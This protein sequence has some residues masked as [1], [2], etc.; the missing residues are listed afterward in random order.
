MPM[1]LSFGRQ[2]NIVRFLASNIIKIPTNYFPCKAVVS[3]PPIEQ[4]TE[5][6]RL[7]LVRGLVLNTIRNDCE[8]SSTVATTNNT[9]I[10]YA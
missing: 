10:N 7:Q 3:S 2:I 5:I 1:H 9:S 8:G 6:Q 4:L